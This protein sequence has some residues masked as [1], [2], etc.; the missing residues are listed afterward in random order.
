MLGRPSPSPT[1]LIPALVLT[2]HPG[3]LLLDRP[4]AAID[5][6]GRA[7]DRGAECVGGRK[8]HVACALCEPLR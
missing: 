5:C 3:K 8:P 6:C 4:E 1:S 2:H 7:V